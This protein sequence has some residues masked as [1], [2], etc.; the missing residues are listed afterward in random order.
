MNPSLL[1]RVEA[2]AEQG[3]RLAYPTRS[4]S[5]VREEDGAVVIAMREG[6]IESA[7]DGFRCRLWSPV[8]ESATEWVDRPAKAERLRHCRL[9]FLR[10]GADGLVALGP[11]AEI[12]RGCVFPL[13]VERIGPEF[14][15]FWG[16]LAVCPSEDA[17]ARRESRTS[18]AQSRFATS[19]SITSVAPPPIACTRASRVM[20]SMADSRM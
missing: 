9:A 18:C 14:W 8:I 19:S 1:S 16:S 20:R 7:F 12:E 15:A 4:W 5:G 10:G 6:E 13:R 3:V 17:G 2:F 11:A